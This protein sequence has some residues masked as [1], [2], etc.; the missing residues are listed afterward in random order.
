MPPT[1]WA[2]DV[3]VLFGGRGAGKSMA[4]SDA[5]YRHMMGPP[6]DPAV[7]GG[8]RGVFLAPTLGD[9]GESFESPAGLQSID[10]NVKMVVRRGGTRIEFPNGSNLRALG[11]YTRQEG[12]RLRARSNNC[13]IFIEELAACRQIGA[14][15][16]NMRLGLRLGPWRKIFAATTPRS[17]PFVRSLIKDPEVS[18]STA[19]MFENPHLPDEYKQRILKLYEG[20]RLYRQEVLGELIDDV[21]GACLLYTSPSPRDLSTSRM[22]SSA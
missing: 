2:G 13:A 20:T 22:P 14:A 4:L 5:C 6:C 7:P 8:H 3:H 9:V 19:T 21:F 15:W 18:V 17:R 16:S 10:P 1:E 12:E 11:C